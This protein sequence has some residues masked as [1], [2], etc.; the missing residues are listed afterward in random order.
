MARK[1][2]VGLDLKQI[3]AILK[4]AGRAGVI[5]LKFGDL[6]VRFH[7]PSSTR[8]IEQQIEPS[9]K[10]DPA[11]MGPQDGL[12]GDV[13]TPSVAQMTPEMQ[14]ELEEAQSLLDDPTRFEAEMIDRMING[15][16]SRDYE[17]AGHRRTK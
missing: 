12:S 9:T 4:E 11:E 7:Q 16:D 10:L 8:L 13:P 17:G 14:R 5:E 15:P 6:E 2:L 3:S 1:S